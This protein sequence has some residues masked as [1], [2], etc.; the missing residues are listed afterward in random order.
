[1][2][3]MNSTKINDLNMIVFYLG[4]VTECITKII[5]LNRQIQESKGSV[6]ECI[7]VDFR[8]RN[9]PS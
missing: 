2:I 5:L 7:R 4:G 3:E 9:V 8:A 1:M 6:T